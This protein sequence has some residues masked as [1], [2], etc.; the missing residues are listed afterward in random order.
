MGVR[1][2]VGHRQRQ[3]EAT[4][5][6]L[7][8]AAR[9]LFAARG[10]AATTIAAISAEADIPV[11]T[12]YSALGSKPR[13]LARITDAW[14]EEART[15]AL[16]A[17]TTR[18][19]DPVRR[20]ALFA[21]LNRRQLEVGLD[22]VTTYQDAARTDPGIARVLGRI[23]AAREG[24]MRNLLEA[25]APGFRPGLGVDEALDVTLALTVPEVYRTLVLERGWTA[26]RYEA[27]LA[28][29]LR[30]QLLRA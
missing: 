23:L 2:P 17:A 9:R 11:P 15:L 8:A 29:T 1:G 27:W 16:A 4:K 12:I 22:V 5:D 28:G 14:M 19:T 10:Y 18:E 7:A 3:A 25:V 26:A 30:D 24:E 6:H 21:E 13:I 20:L